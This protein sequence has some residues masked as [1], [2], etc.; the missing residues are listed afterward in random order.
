MIPLLLFR[1]TD[2]EHGDWV[3]R[4][5][6]GAPCTTISASVV[7]MVDV[8][9]AD[10]LDVLGGEVGGLA[11]GVGEPGEAEGLQLLL[12]HIE[13]PEHGLGLCCMPVAFTEASSFATP[14]RRHPDH[15]SRALVI[16]YAGTVRISV[17]TG[18]P[19]SNKSRSTS[20]IK[21]MD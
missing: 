21:I 18:Y 4:T 12:Q 1:L 14:W 9:S 20:G 3:L 7:L 16:G 17:I 8:S 15:G 19:C 2:F 6:G 5:A 13:G 11:A 10:P